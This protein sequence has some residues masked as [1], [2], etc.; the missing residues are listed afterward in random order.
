LGWMF[1]WICCFVCISPKKSVTE[2][3]ATTSH[4]M[5]KSRDRGLGHRTSVGARYGTTIARWS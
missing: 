4:M 3:I 5:Q 1:C 2:G